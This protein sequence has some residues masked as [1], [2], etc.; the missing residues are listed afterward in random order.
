[1]GRQLIHVTSTQARTKYRLSRG[2]LRILLPTY[3]GRLVDLLERE[4]SSQAPT[5]LK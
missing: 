2:F 5:G 3:V 1:M 4:A